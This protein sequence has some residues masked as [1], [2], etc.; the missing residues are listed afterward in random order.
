M[1]AGETDVVKRLDRFSKRSRP[2]AATSIARPAGDKGAW[3]RR[4]KA[5]FT[6]ARRRWPLRLDGWHNGIEYE[7]NGAYLEGLNILKHAKSGQVPT[8]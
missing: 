5:I 3:H 1:I 6:A 7:P 2:V 8:A 4:G